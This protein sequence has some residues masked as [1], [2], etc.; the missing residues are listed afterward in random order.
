MHAGT[1]DFRF[2]FVLPVAQLLL[3]LAVL[4]PMRGTI[5]LE[6]R[7]SIRASRSSSRFD[8]SPPAYP[9][10]ILPVSG[11]ELLLPRIRERLL[12]IPS[13]LNLPSALVQIPQAIWSST[14]QAWAPKYMDF[15]T[16]RAISWPVIGVLFWWVAGRGVDALIAA[17]HRLISPSISWAETALA[18]ATVACGAIFCMLP[19]V[20]KIDPDDAGRSWHLL[21]MAGAMWVLLGCSTIAAR[22]VQWR[23]RRKLLLP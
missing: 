20:G 12:W 7:A 21:S 19:F 23:C 13:M 18:A 10:T 16:W 6:A 14:H 1:R 5:A 22:V 17:R 15:L 9:R 11:E 2:R 8:I 4:W 3:C